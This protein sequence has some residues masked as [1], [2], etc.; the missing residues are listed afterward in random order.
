[1]PSGATIVV[2]LP[3]NAPGLSVG[4]PLNALIVRASSHHRVLVVPVSAVHTAADG[5]DYIEVERAGKQVRVA[6][7]QSMTAGGN[8]AVEPVPGDVLRP[9]EQVVIPN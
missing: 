7:I 4:V 6:V 9:G 8:V 5:S 3:R 1:V 2:A